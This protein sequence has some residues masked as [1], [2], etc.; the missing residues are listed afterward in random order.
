[1]KILITGSKGML[2]TQVINDLERGY[3]EL[4]DVPA[5]LKGAQLVLADVDE[6]F[7]LTD[8]AGNCLEGEKSYRCV[9]TI[10]DGQIVYRD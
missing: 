7:S 8:T 6:V 3:T 9:L 5:A 1:M 2:A 4:G 10:S